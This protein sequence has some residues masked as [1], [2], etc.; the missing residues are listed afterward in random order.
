[1]KPA[2]PSM[3]KH[4]LLVC[5]ASFLLLIG[6]NLT[7]VDIP[8]PIGAPNPDR[9]YDEDGLTNAVEAEIGTYPWNPYSDGDLLK[10]GEDAV[11]LNGDM[12]VP[13]APET[14]YAIVDLGEVTGV[15]YPVGINDQ[16]QVL[17][18]SEVLSLWTSGQLTTIIEEETGG[19]VSLLQDGSVFYHGAW[20]ADSEWGASPIIYYRKLK[21][22]TPTGT[23]DEGFAED[24]YDYPWD[25]NPPAPPPAPDRAIT[26]ACKDAFASPAASAVSAMEAYVATWRP[27]ISPPFYTGVMTHAWVSRINDAHVKTFRASMECMGELDSADES[28]IY[29]R[30]N[31]YALVSGWDSVL[32]SASWS[33]SFAR[34]WQPPDAAPVPLNEGSSGNGKEVGEICVNDDGFCAYTYVNAPNSSATSKG[35]I[36]LSNTSTDIQNCKSVRDLNR[37][38]GTT[39]GPYILGETSSGAAALWCYNAG[40]LQSIELGS[41]AGT[42]GGGDVVGRA[43][44]NRLEIP[45]GENLWRNSRLRPLAE[46]CGN[47]VQWPGINASQISPNT[48]LMIATATKVKDDQGNNLATQDQKGHSLLLIPVEVVPNFN[49]DETI[50]LTGTKDRGKVTTDKPYP[51]WINDDND[52]GDLGGD[53]VPGGG[54]NATNSVVDGARDL[55]DFAPLFLDIKL[56]LDTLPPGTCTYK[57]KQEDGALNF[58]YTDLTPDHA[59]DYLTINTE[60][61][62]ETY[63]PDADQKPN[64]AT[65]TQITSGGVTLTEAFLNKIKDDGKGVILVEGRSA[66]TKPLIVEVY[67]GTDKLGEYSFPLKITTVDKMF[68]HKNLRPDSAGWAT[69]MGEPENFPDANTVNKYFLFLHG[70]NVS[71]TSAKGWHAETFKRLYWSGSKARFVGVTWFGNQGQTLGVTPNYHINVINAQTAAQD[72]ASTV[73]GLGG[74][75]YAAGHSL[76]NMVVSTAISDYGANIS[77]YYMLNAAVAVESYDGSVQTT[78]MWHNEWTDNPGDDPTHAAYDSRLLCSNWHERFASSDHRSELTWRDRLANTGGTRY[79]NFYSSSENVVGNHTGNVP[80]ISE[81]ILSELVTGLGSAISGQGGEDLGRYAWCYQEKLKGLSSWKIL[82]SSYGGWAFNWVDWGIPLNPQ[83]T[84]FRE[85]YPGETGPVLADLNELKTKP[86]FFKGVNEADAVFTSANGSTYAQTNRNKLLAEMVP[87]LSN[88][89]GANAV[90][91]L[92]NDAGENRNFDMPDDYQNGWPASRS[93][94]HWL[95]SDL[96]T[97]AYPY[98]YQLYDAWVE[99][100]DLK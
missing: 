78:G 7:G 88:G 3:P 30:Y 28:N 18:G 58:V 67:K 79:F 70:Y 96:K 65:S 90:Q 14:R 23:T 87:A 52:S 82:G 27:D 42:L 49:R 40:G 31:C 57:L 92:T 56:M 13:A 48:G 89:A 72:L 46:L 73:N 75:V 35:A 20:E 93:N 97:I 45:M 25:Q 60:N 32:L 66:S 100:G 59:K 24:W 15:G 4:W 19:F 44:S 36:F 80:S 98:I 95:H 10:D 85:R 38:L 17:L 91:K 21:R 74:Q 99:I 12:K 50:D 61:Q 43:L 63:G 11:P 1:M 41:T 62:V 64:V 69:A 68:R 5:I 77:D 94:N 76:G 33:A 34:E 6:N 9:D 16:G 37:K 53:D 84:I 83:E 71:S 86:F 29:M 54:N 8:S 55:V 47:P 2:A 39:E 22:W 81:S 51:L 26:T